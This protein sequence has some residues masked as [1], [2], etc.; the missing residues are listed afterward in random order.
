VSRYDGVC[1]QT[2]KGRKAAASRRT[3]KVVERGLHRGGHSG[4][5]CGLGGVMVADFFGYGD[6]LI[7]A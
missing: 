2:D 6:G 3:P 4:E 5:K 1:A 7:H